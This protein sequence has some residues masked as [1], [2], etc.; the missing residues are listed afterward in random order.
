MT[1]GLAAFQCFVN[2]VFMDFL[3]DFLT[4]FIDDLLIYSE[5]NG[6]HAASLGSIYRSLD[7]KEFDG[8]GKEIGR[9]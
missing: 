9:R 4:A 8:E 7:P 3:D 5:C 6:Q 1:N 2:E